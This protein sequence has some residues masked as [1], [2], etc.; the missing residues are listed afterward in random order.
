M[1]S[2]RAR[3]CERKEQ[4]ERRDSGDGEVPARPWDSQAFAGPEN[5]ERGQQYP[6]HELQR[7]LGNARERPL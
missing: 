2:D 1:T 3:G 7:V 6:D 4:A 5:A